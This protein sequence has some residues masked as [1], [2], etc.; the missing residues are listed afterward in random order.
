IAGTGS[1]IAIRSGNMNLG[2]EGQVYIGGFTGCIILNVM[3]G[4]ASVVFITALF[5]SAA[6]GAIMAT[7]S[8]LL[9]ELRGA[10]VLLTTFLF[11]AAVIPLV[12]GFI[13]ASKKSSETNM[14]AL[15]YI[16]DAYKMKQWLSPSPLTASFVLAIIV[17]ILAWH[18][19]YKTDFGRKMSIWGTAPLFARYCG[20]SSAINSSITLAAS[21]ALHAL[22]GFFAVTGTYYTCHKGFYTNMGW[23]ALNVALIAKS[24]P[25]TAIP[26]S[27]VLSWLFTSASRVSL[28][29]GFSFD[30]A[31]IVQG[32]ILFSIAIPRRRS[33]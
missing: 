7:F 14:L 27:I 10:K 32:I 2:G 5:A 31:G 16:D 21:G 4:P 8:A 3:K 30:I 15:P 24:N 22:T 13:T 20:Y 29:Q 23:N 9:K 19:M 1:A 25:L 12:D 11:S 17:C 6:S 33:S 26:T 28:T 18:L